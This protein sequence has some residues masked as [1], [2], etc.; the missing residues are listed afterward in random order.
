M[1]LKELM[2]QAE[3]APVEENPYVLIYS[4]KMKEYYPGKMD[5]AGNIYLQSGMEPTPVHEVPLFQLDSE[6]ARAIAAQLWSVDEEEW[7]VRWAPEST[8]KQWW[9]AYANLP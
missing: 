2:D 5:D 1:T 6:E 8:A 9:E 3:P 4:F 7:S